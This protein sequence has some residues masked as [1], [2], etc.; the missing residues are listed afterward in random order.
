M[1]LPAAQCRT[2]FWLIGLALLRSSGTLGRGRRRGLGPAG[3]WRGGGRRPSGRRPGGAAGEPAARS[4]GPCARPSDRGDSAAAA[5]GPDQRA[6]SRAR[7]ACPAR[8]AAARRPPSAIH[9]RDANDDDFVVREVGA[10]FYTHFRGLNA[11]ADVRHAALERSVDFTRAAC[12][13]S[14]RRPLRRYRRGS[15]PLRLCNYVTARYRGGFWTRTR[16]PRTGSSR[17]GGC[18]SQRG[19][20]ATVELW[21]PPPEIVQCQ[22]AA[23][24]RPDTGKEPPMGSPRSDSRAAANVP[25]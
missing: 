22:R 12:A 14:L 7:A 21:S 8:I 24:P 1:N 16:R 25:G 20:S 17:S 5:P 2:P 4:G 19:D 3:G 13:H 10:P 11:V 15:L 9:L 23:S 18:H 6:L